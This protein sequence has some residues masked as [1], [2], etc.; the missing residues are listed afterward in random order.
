MSR[1]VRLCE[2]ASPTG[3]EAEVGEL[4]RAELQALGLT[5]TEDDAAEAAGAGCGNLHCLVEG[6]GEG[7]VAFC[8]HLDTVP[9]EGPIEVVLDGDEVYRS[10]GETI[11]G[12][13]NKA[14]IAVMIELAAGLVEEPAPTGVELLF[15]VAEETGLRGAAAFDRTSLVSER[16]FVLDLAEEIGRIVTR[17]PFYHRLTARITGVEAHAGLVPEEG[18]SAIVAASRAIAAMELGRLDDHTTANVGLIEGGTAPNVVPGQCALVGEARS[19]DPIRAAQVTGEMAQAIASAAS[20]SG[21]E[22]EV[23]TSILHQGY[24][25]PD[26][27]PALALAEQALSAS[28]FEPERVSTGGGSDVN[29]FRPEGIDALLLANGTFANHTADE[30]VPRA[31]LVAMLEVCRALVEG[32]PEHC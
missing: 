16:M 14:A 28:G 11:L 10:A 26:D 2:T 29:I 9:H 1:F 24:E 7:W 25:V 32:A 12:A 23:E 4:V 30:N 18:R 6:Q 27:S 20:E 22:V 5:V 21:C 31:N 15:T 19:L 8:A 17:S 13:D 3:S